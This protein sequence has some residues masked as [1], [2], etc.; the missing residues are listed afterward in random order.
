MSAHVVIA[1]IVAVL[2]LARVVWIVSFAWP[3]SSPSRAPRWERRRREYLRRQL[4]ASL[5]RAV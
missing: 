5:I 4:R 2:S 3:V 1:V